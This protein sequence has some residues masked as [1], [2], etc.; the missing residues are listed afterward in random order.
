MDQ[1]LSG[2]HRVVVAGTHPLGISR[3][4]SRQGA[5]GASAPV[6]IDGPVVKVTDSVQTYATAIRFALTK[7][8]SYRRTNASRYCSSNGLLASLFKRA[9]RRDL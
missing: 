1:Q 4:V 5:M 9:L 2:K 7:Q 8:Y 3:T 6:F